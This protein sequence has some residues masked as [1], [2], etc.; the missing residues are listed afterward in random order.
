MAMLMREKGAARAYYYPDQHQTNSVAVVTIAATRILCSKHANGLALA[1]GVEEATENVSV[2]RLKANYAAN[3]HGLGTRRDR[4]KSS[5][6]RKILLDETCQLLL[7]W[8]IT[9]V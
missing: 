8:R 9:P 7:Y 6:K 2:D 5:S 3:Y 1:S 4:G